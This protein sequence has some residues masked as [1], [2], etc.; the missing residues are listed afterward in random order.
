MIKKDVI[1]G[2]ISKYAQRLNSSGNPVR[3]IN[4]FDYERAAESIKDALLTKEGL[5]GAEV[6]KIT[7]ESF[8]EE[9]EEYIKTTLLIKYLVLIK[10]AEDSEIK[11]LL[12]DKGTKGFK[13]LQG[14]I[15]ETEGSYKDAPVTE[16]QLLLIKTYIR[17][18][19]VVRNEEDLTGREAD[20][21]IKCLKNGKRVKPGYFYYYLKMREKN[22]EKI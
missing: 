14:M 11:T 12:R 4:N 19:G 5:R 1:D 16:A 22:S 7:E 9:L 18:N 17:T 8:T 20:Q 15:G 21:I 6:K 10:E 3:M 13:C 2:Y